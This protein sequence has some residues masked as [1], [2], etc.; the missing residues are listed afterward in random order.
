MREAPTG[1][2]G[3]DVVCRRPGKLVGAVN[4]LGQACG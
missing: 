3:G 4:L 1:S 2:E